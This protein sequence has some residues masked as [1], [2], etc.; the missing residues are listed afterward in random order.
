MSVD[1]V[2]C[3]DVFRADISRLELKR[4]K[5]SADDE[6]WEYRSFEDDSRI[7]LL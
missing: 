5:A 3:V 4:W 2:S 7:M 1:K 6:C